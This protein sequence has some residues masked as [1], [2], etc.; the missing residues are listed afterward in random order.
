MFDIIGDVHGCARETMLLLRQLG[1]NGNNIHPDGRKL[2]FVGDYIDRGPYPIATLEFMMEL[3]ELGHYALLGNHEAY[4]VKWLEGGKVSMGG[5][6]DQTVI[7]LEKEPLVWRERLLQWLQARPTML[8]L[9]DGKVRIVH[10]AMPAKY[11]ASDANAKKREQHA[12]HGPDESWA[13]NYD[14]EP[15]IVVGHKSGKDVRIKGTGGKVV[16]I[17]TGC[18]YGGKLTAARVD[19]PDLTTWR[20]ESYTA[21]HVYNEDHPE[22]R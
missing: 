19:S 18:V 16:M 14:G 22:Y 15:T 9:F 17:D 1:Y 13:E 3:T 5:G 20:F 11:L 21:L 10:A 7:E 2:V 12:I 6:F 8:S 4:M